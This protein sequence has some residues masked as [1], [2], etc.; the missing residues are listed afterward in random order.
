MRRPGPTSRSWLISN[1]LGGVIQTVALRIALPEG[2][3]WGRDAPDPTEGCT[4]S[5]SV[6]CTEKLTANDVGTVGGE[7]IWDIV[8]ERP[9]FYEITA[10]VEAEQPDPDL[11]NNS[12]TSKLEV[13]Q[14]PTGEGGSVAASTVRLT[15]VKPKAG[16][17]VTATVRVAAAGTPVRPV[18]ITCSGSVGGATLKGTPRAGSGSATCL[19]R[20]PKTAKGKTLRGTISF[21]AREKRF[22]KRFSTKLG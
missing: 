8:A 20:P 3:R 16:S 14:P 10:S 7:W 15:P 22:T 21:T 18:R 2:L 5:T 11:S 17:A 6:V 19:Y 12:F 9:G 4:V 1:S 13:V